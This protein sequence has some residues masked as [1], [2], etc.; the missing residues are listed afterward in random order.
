MPAT[1]RGI[2]HNLL[3][4]EYVASTDEVT[5]FFSSIKYLN[6]FMHRYKDNR[7][8]VRKKFKKIIGDK[9]INS[10][11]LA[12]IML[13]R[14]IE[15]RGFYAILK[16]REID[17]QELYRFALEKMTNQTTQDWSKMQKRN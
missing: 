16:G 17:W 7:L 5:L 9:P 10:D 13:Y 8:E 14:T 4:S 6:K 11:M 1:R 2:Y 3:E 12:D 15:T